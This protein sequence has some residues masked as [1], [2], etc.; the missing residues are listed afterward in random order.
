MIKNSP[1][2]PP[3]KKKKKKK[4]K[5]LESDIVADHIT[6]MAMQEGDTTEAGFVSR[7]VSYIHAIL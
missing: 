4:D 2:H 6:L 1:P 5:E 7:S 3:T